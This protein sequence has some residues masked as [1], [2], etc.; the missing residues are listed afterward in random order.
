M[1]PSAL[2]LVASAAP[3]A[4]AG[5]GLQLD[6]S[7]IAGLRATFDLAR[8]PEEA[9][10]SECR[11]SIAPT[12]TLGPPRLVRMSRDFSF[13]GETHRISV[14][15]DGNLVE[16]SRAI[17][18]ERCVL[19]SGFDVDDFYEAVVFD[20]AEEAFFE[21]LLVSLR[22]LRD[23]LALDDA[24]YAELLTAFV[25]SLRYEAGDSMPKHPIAAFADATGDCDEKSALLGGL[26]AREGWDAALLLFADDQHMAVGLRSP[27][28]EYLDTGYAFIE[29]TAPSYIGRAPF[30]LH[31]PFPRVIE[32]GGGDRAYEP[33]EKQLY[34]ARA[35]RAADLAVASWSGDPGTEDRAARLVA[36][37]LVAAVEGDLDTAYAAVK[38]LFERP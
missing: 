29:A 8:K 28:I 4:L 34:I 38:E 27:D 19:G 20:P 25:Q 22:A 13:R 36:V 15:L 32:L 30:G 12:A 26:L 37:E 3:L 24:G 18:R 33:G 1:K 17:G 11:L 5:C 31:G 35:V 9:I 16:A 2:L 23:E 7:R 6:V 10:L 21:S 14:E